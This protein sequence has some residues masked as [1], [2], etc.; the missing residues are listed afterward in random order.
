MPRLSIARAPREP[1][2]HPVLVTS[3][4]EIGETCRDPRYARVLRGRNG[5]ELARRVDAA[6]ER[7]IERIASRAGELILNGSDY[8][9]A[10]VLAAD[11]VLPRSGS[12]AGGA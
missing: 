6:A 4:E 10:L 11:Q 5:D 9:P 1:V 3:R 12:N 2:W 7:Q 8:W